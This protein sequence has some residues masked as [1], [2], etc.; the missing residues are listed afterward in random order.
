M[1]RGCVFY[2]VCFVG[3]IS[4]VPWTD[5]RFEMVFCVL[6]IFGGRIEVGRLFGEIAGMAWNSWTDFS[7]SCVM[8]WVCN[9]GLF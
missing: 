4:W 5:G 9:E 7:S 6:D 8:G 3:K 1:K 2:I